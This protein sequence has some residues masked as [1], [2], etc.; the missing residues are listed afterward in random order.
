M[1]QVTKLASVALVGLTLLAG[2]SSKDASATSTTGGNPEDGFVVPGTSGQDVLLDKTWDRGCYSAGSP[3]AWQ[4]SER[5]LTG[6]TLVWTWTDYE[7]GSTTPDCETGRVD[8][9]SATQT[10]H[11][12]G[13]Q[14]PI[15]WVDADGKA[16]SPPAGL[17]KVT[18]ADGVTATATEAK[19]KVDT[20]ARADE[21]NQV[22]ACGFTDWKVGERDFMDCY[23][24]GLNPFKATI[25][26][27]DS[28]T[29]TRINIYDG[30]GD[31]HDYPADMPNFQP[32]HRERNMP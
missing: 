1:I 9:F 21:L 24:T 10:L 11:Y 13:V 26:V 32:H 28:T 5:T 15:H 29:T 17:E 30:I 3:G 14:V 20:Q 7:N 22:K 2:C 12:D 16:S 8:V 23:T 27:D 19:F 18:K 31:P 4:H 25:V 6:L